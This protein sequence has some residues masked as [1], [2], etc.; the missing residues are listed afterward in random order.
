M[1]EYPATLIQPWAHQIELWKRSYGQPNFYIAHDMGCGKSKGA[2]DYFNSQNLKRVLVLCPK[3]VV[4]GWGRQFRLHSPVPWKVFPIL[5]EKSTDTTITK[6]KRVKN[7]LRDAG[8]NDKVAIVVN[9]DT[10]WLPGMGPSY[11]KNNRIT[12]TGILM[13]QDWDGL[14]CDEAHRLKSP[15]GK[16]SWFVKRI[17]PQIQNKRFLSGTPMPHSPQDVYGQ[18]RALDPSIFGTS[19]VRFRQRYC[20]MGGY[21]NKQVVSY[22]NLDEL[23]ALF[24]SIAHMVT[25]EEALDLPQESNMNIYFDL[26]P[27]TFKIYKEFEQELTAA[28]NNKSMTAKNG[29]TKLLRLAQMTGGN[30]SFDDHTHKTIES[31]KVDTAT[32]LVQDLPPKEPVIIFAWFIPEINALKE[33]LEKKPP[34]GPGRKVHIL[35]GQ[36]QTPSDFIDSVWTAEDSDVLIVQ[37]QAGGEGVDFSVARYCIYVST[38]YSLGKYRQS[39]R[40]VNRPNEWGHDP[41][42]KVFYYHILAN[43]TVDIKISKGI[44]AKAKL[45]DFVLEEL[46]DKGHIEEEDI[47]I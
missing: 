32:E 42:H 3:A 14:C 2:I 13:Q 40:R 45:V 1:P 23:N 6:A 24:Y 15:G 5:K 11:N 38:G 16:Q 33:K 25:A 29:L 30:I 43:N 7:I 26:E 41:D 34:H 36:H 17:A 28:I 46:G 18:Y 4:P 19:F 12:D 22:Q 20:V 37:M 10:A 44:K 8:P 35:S 47:L 39:R 27:R 31:N 9:Y 21:E